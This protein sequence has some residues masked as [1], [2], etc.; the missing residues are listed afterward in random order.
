MADETTQAGQAAGEGAGEAGAAAAAE[1]KPGGIRA[2]LP[3][4]LAVVLMPVLA[5]GTFKIKGMMDAKGSAAAKPEKAGAGGQAADSSHE[6]KAAEEEEEPEAGAHGAKSSG[7]KVR[8]DTRLAVPLTRLPITY[9]PADKSK[10][11]QDF[12]KYVTLD[13]KGEPKEVAE[14]EKITVNIARTGGT[15]YAVG[16]FYLLSDSETFLEQLN[17]HRESLIDAAHGAM[18]NKTLEEYDTPEFKNVL[19]GEMIQRFNSVFG[20]NIVKNVRVEVIIQ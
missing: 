18:A 9:K 16:R 12:P 19:R 7:K 8:P 20:K 13:L 14:P 15:R 6:S 5:L 1:A 2:F 3:L 11:T 17:L 4:I 10:E